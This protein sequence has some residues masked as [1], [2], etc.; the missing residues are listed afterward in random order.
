MP[1][2]VVETAGQSATDA[3]ALVAELGG[4]VSLGIVAAMLLAGASLAI[5]VTSAFVERRRPFALLRL[6]GMPVSRLRAVL[7][8]EAAAPLVA[9]AAMS[10]VL[11]M[12]VAQ[13]LLRALPTTTVPPPDPGVVALLAVALAGALA[14]VL[15]AMPLV[16][17]VTSTEATRFE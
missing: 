14:V 13:V 7:L 10:A 17:R 12:I 5:A 15:A 16:D 9:V 3:I 1:T 6:S 8:L 11:G 4:V 2:S